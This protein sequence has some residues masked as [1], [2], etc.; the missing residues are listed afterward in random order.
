MRTGNLQ[1]LKPPLSA[2]LLDGVIIAAYLD[3]CINMNRSSQEYWENTKQII[4][5]FHPE[6]KSVFD[7][8]QKIEL[9]GFI[10]N[11]V[12]MKI[13]LPD[14]KK[15]QLKSFCTNIL[16]TTTT[17]IRKIASILGKITSSFP[18]AKFG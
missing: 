2:L 12:T 9:L 10:L 6:P 17:E 15:R 7:P 4:Q 8:S 1:S 18:A 3:G 16:L 11:S 5:T 13:I 14:E